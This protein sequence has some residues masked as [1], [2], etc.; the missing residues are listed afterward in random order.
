M[1]PDPRQQ[2]PPALDLQGVGRDFGRLRALDGIHLR[3]AA[4]ER[5]ALVGPSG[6]GKSTL[7]GLCNGTLHPSRG[8]RL[9]L[10][11]DP[12]ALGPNAL[13]ALQR[14]VGS[15]HQRL[16]LVPNLS[17]AQNVLAG[18]LG[19]WSA[20]FSLYSLVRPKDRDLRIAHAALQRVGI[21]E[22]LFARTEQ[23]STGQQQRVALA[24]VL[25]Q[26]PRLLLADEPTASVDPE[27]GRDIMRLMTE[28]SHDQGI[29]LVV[30]LHTLD[31]AQQHFDRIVG[32]REGR[33]AFDAPSK[34]VSETMLEA[35]YR[36]DE[37][38]ADESP[39]GNASADAT[40]NATATATGDAPPGGVP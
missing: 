39:L 9:I 6:A 2:A 7:L 33:L 26:Q 21:P 27:R 10:G 22:K 38:N 40:S 24:R 3:V 18:R 13:R 28:L 19:R 31:F 11:E 15:V 20:L 17:V 12:Q 25:V 14:Q 23:L 8:Q 37:G 1:H 30:S 5:V 4:G 32:L 16:D 29:T 35:L 34:E 36:L